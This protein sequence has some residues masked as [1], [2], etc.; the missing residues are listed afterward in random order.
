VAEPKL[1]KTELRS[2]QLRLTQL[3]RYLPTL[4]L[5]K[6][7]LQL[8]VDQVQSAIEGVTRGLA[9]EEEVVA[10]FASLLYDVEGFALAD[11][12]AIDAVDTQ[13]ENIAGVDVPIFLGVHFSRT[14]VPRF[15]LPVWFESA[16]EKLQKLLRLR[17]ERRVLAKRKSA[18]EKELREVSIRVNLFEKVLIPRAEQQIRRI[19]I[20]LGD[21]Q[22]S[23]VAQAKVSKQKIQ[24]RLE[25][26]EELIS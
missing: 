17:E 6:A 21:Q 9:E 13:I 16:A 24:R 22:L 7:M 1:T 4:Q 23:A 18:L 26:E 14:Q 3:N 12:M 5:K 20:F 15:T 11:E 19:K 25:E 2:T 10:S 8:E